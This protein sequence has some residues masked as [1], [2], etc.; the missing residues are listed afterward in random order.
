[1]DAGLLPCFPFGTDFTDVERRLIP[2]LETLKAA[3]PLKLVSL[4]LRGLSAGGDHSDCLDRMDLAHP[5]GIAQ[6]FY[7]SLVRGALRN[8]EQGNLS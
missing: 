4:V 7:A 1:A 6:R 5:K 2:A 3:S 8:G